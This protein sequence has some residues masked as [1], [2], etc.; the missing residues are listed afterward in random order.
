MP[1]LP[2]EI[3]VPT[4]GTLRKYGMI[5]EEWLDIVRRQGNCCSI[6][7][8]VPKSGRLAIDHQHVPKWKKMVPSERRRY[9]RGIVCFLCNGKCV[10]K[11][12]TLERAVSVVRYLREYERRRPK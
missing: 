3:R 8:R 9:V 2:P 4:V 5:A 11:W 10:S 12:V 7:R 6:C 1:T